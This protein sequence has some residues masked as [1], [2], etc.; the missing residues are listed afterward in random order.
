MGGGISSLSKV[1]VVARSQREAVDLD[2]T[3]GQV[4][5]DSTTVD[6]AGN[7]GNLSSGWCPLPLN[8]GCW[9][10][11]ADRSASH[12][13][14]RTLKDRAGEAGGTRR[15]GRSS[16]ELSL[17]GVH[18]TAAPIELSYPDPAGSRSAGLLPTGDPVDV[19]SV[20]ERDY[21]VS[22]VDAA[23]PMVVIEAAS[24]GFQCT[25]SPEQIDADKAALV[26]LEKLR[27]AGAVAMR[28]CA[29]AAGA[30]L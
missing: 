27:R 11:Q 1:M 4:A 9:K 5:V 17:P 16:G 15:A 3:F 19:L 25:E 26:L 30:A 13:S 23:L 14:T 12:Y 2:Y 28:L 18:G 8:P 6:Y 24:L 22:L 10:L 21:P 7:C 20:D 29:T